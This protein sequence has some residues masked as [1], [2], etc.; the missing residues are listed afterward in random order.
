MDSVDEPGSQYTHPES[1]PLWFPSSLPSEIR[2]RAEMKEMCDA[3]RRLREPQADDALAD[4]HRFRRTIQGLWQFKKLN[5][6]GTGNKPN[7]RM[8]DLYNRI[9]YKLQRAANRYRIAYAALM[10]LDPNGSWRER[11]KE[12]NPVD[13][14][15]P[16]RDPDH[17]EDAKTSSGRFIPSWIWLVPR[18]P[19]ERGDDQTEAEFNDT[20]CAEWAQTRARMC[21]WD[22]EVLIIQEEMRR[23]LAFFEWKSRWWLEQGNR[24][25]GLES[26]IESGVIAYAHK[27]A[28]LC[29]CM[30]ARCAVYWLPIM[31][32]YSIDPTWRGKYEKM[33]M[34]DTH[35]EPHSDSDSED[36]EGLGQK[37]DKSDVGDVEIDEIFDIE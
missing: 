14:R 28:N 3:E 37:D 2:R 11:L 18:S 25:Q 35:T 34:P 22:E 10:A 33:P 17:P 9:D 32:K 21:R 26:S 5:V 16:G 23:V 30:A 8:L 4:V 20:M 31:K 12:L 36:D 19:Q 15:G 1:A 6:S 27:Q 7:T 24:R 29:L 13:I